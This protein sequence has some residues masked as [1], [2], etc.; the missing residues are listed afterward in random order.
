MTDGEH[1][2]R[3]AESEQH[4]SEFVVGVVRV[5]NQKCIVVEE[6]R[7][8]LLEGDAVL[9]LVRAVFFTRPIQTSSAPYAQ[10]TYTAPS[11]KTRPSKLPLGRGIAKLRSWSPSTLL[12]PAGQ[13]S[14][15]FASFR[16]SP[17][18]AW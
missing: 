2:Q 4:E 14:R 12:G 8:C 1:A 7:L 10:C 18:R 15:L 17:L 16:A 3:R 9:V 13:P 6:Y 11:C 5:V